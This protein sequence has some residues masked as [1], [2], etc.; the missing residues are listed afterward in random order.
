MSIYRP[1]A[2]EKGDLDRMHRRLFVVGYSSRRVRLDAHAAEGCDTPG[3]SQVELND[4][5]GN[6]HKKVDAEQITSRLRTISRRRSRLQL[7]G[8]V[9]F[10][11]AECDFRRPDFCGSAYGM[12]LA[13]CLKGLT[14]KRIDDFKNYL[15]CQ[16]GELDC[17]VPAK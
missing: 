8:R 2:K 9:A 10:R 16:E 11:D 13:I 3:K 12:I 1:W 4:C 14:S 6:A 5:Y 15:K 17:P 7:K